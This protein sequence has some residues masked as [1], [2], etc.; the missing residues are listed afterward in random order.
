MNQRPTILLYNMMIITNITRFKLV[1]VRGSV[2]HKN[3]SVTVQRDATISSLF[4][5]CKVTLHV[6]GV[7]APII[8]ST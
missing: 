2:R 5:Y 7:V 4:I 3:L 1:Y 8:R 6:S